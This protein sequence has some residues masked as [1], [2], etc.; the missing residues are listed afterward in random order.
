M[1][2]E[3]SL[4]FNPQTKTFPMMMTTGENPYL[5]NHENVQSLTC[6]GM[7]AGFYN[8]TAS[9]VYDTSERPGAQQLE[10]AE[11]RLALSGRHAK[12]NLIS[13]IRPHDSN[14]HCFGLVG[15]AWNVVL[16]D[17]I[18]PKNKYDPNVPDVSIIKQ[19]EHEKEQITDTF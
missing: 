9:A 3:E 2:G 12:A 16:T 5:Y 10:G 14:R 15:T 18:P 17:S 6:L 8:I 7:I 1:L 19:P 13:N 11:Y 4:K